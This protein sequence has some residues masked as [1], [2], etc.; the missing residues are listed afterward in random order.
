MDVPTNRLTVLCDSHPEKIAA[1]VEEEVDGE[2]LDAIFSRNLSYVQKLTLLYQMACGVA[3]IH[4]AGRIHRNFKPHNV[5]VRTDGPLKI[6]DF[7]IATILVDGEATQIGKGIRGLLSAR[8][9][10]QTAVGR[11]HELRHVFDRCN[12]SQVLVERFSLCLP[13]AFV[14]DQIE[15]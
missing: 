8:T 14:S 15:R 1:N 6:F 9:S 10:R 3:H 11:L 13:L 4:Q 2:T 12:G 7:G 5:K